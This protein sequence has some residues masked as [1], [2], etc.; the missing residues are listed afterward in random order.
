EEAVA[1]ARKVGDPGRIAEALYNL[2]FVVAG[3]DLGYATRLLDESLELFRQVGDEHGVAQILSL[4]VMPDA[5]A[6]KWGPV[7]TKL[8]ETVAIW[9]R[10]GDRLHLAFDLLWLS[11]AHGRAGHRGAAREAGLEAL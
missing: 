9:R 11:F 6:G 2:S 3:D 8:E 4:L 10:L 5:Q 7:V 1:V